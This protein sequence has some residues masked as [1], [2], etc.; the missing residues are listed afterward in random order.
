MPLESAH[1][2]STAGH[3]VSP[4]SDGKWNSDPLSTKCSVT[5]SLLFLYLLQQLLCPTLPLQ[6]KMV[7]PTPLLV[8]WTH[9]KR[10]R[11]PV[12]ISGTYSAHYVTCHVIKSEFWF[13]DLHS[14]FLS[15]NDLCDVLNAVWEARSKWYN[16]GLELGSSPGTLDTL[17]LK[18][19]DDPDLCITYMIKDWLNNGDP[20]PS[21]AAVIKALKAP[22]VGYGKLAEQL[23]APPHTS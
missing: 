1:K 22:I 19:R 2:T 10:L 5:W 4:A 21:W 13:H 12:R 17:S 3:V 23:C 14:G 11:L 6:D 15:V 20:R 8:H 7:R 16:M 18:G 9:N